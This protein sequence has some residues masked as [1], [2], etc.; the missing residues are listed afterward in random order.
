MNELIMVLTW[1]TQQVTN[2]Q[3]FEELQNFTWMVKTEIK[4]I[5]L[6]LY[7]GTKKKC[8]LKNNSFLLTQ[9]HSYITEQLVSI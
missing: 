7:T 9:I 6:F 1:E 8:K 2:K 3:M 4:I 5:E